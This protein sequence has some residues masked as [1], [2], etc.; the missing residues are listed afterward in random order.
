MPGAVYSSG[1]LLAKLDAELPYLN[2]LTLRLFRNDH[3]PVQGDLAI[4]YQEANFPGYAAQALNG[5][6]AVFLNGNSEAESDEQNRTFQMTG[7]APAN[8]IY[9]YYVTDAAGNFIF[10]ERS[11]SAPFAMNAVGKQYIVQCRATLAHT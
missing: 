2:T 1:G 3:V 11:P 6:G 5:W 4:N 10:G 9:G 7:A 8:D